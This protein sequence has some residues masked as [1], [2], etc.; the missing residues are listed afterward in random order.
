MTNPNYQDFLSAVGDSFCEA[1]LEEP[2]FEDV[3]PHDFQEVLL[4]TVGDPL[5]PE[6]L[7]VAKSDEYIAKIVV[8]CQRYFEVNDVPKEKIVRSIE[9]ALHRWPL[10]SFDQLNS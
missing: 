6:L 7:N 3:C 1:F 10:G 2:E 8:E 9:Q 5:T 4:E